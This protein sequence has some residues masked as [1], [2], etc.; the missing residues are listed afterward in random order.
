MIINV[1]LMVGIGEMNRYSELSAHQPHLVDID[2]KSS[3]AYSPLRII[4]LQQIKIG[5]PFIPNDLSA[6]EASD[7]DDHGSVL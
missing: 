1:R 5:F 4:R 6:G 2:T 3:L 7:G